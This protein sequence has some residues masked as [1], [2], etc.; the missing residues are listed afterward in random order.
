M[1]GG[2]GRESS[3]NGTGDR[4]ADRH[5]VADQRLARR[6]STDLPASCNFNGA[7]TLT[8]TTGDG[9][10]TGRQ[11]LTDT[12]TVAITVN[13]VNDRPVLDLD[14][15]NS[16]GAA[17][18]DYTTTFTEG[19]AAVAI[20]DVDDS[21]HRCRQSESRHPRRSR[22]PIISPPTCCPSSGRCRPASRPPPTIP[23]T[24]VLTLSGA[25]TL[26]AYQ[27]ALRQIAFSNSS[28][29]PSASDRIINIVVNDGAASSVAAHAFIHVVPVDTAPALDLDANDSS[30]ATGADY[31][32][33]FTG[34]GAAIPIADADTL[35]ADADSAN[36][37]SATITL[38]NAE[39]TDLLLVNGTLPHRDH[40]SSFDP[41]TGI[42]TLSGSASL[43]D[44][45]AALRQIEFG[46]SVPNPLTAT[47]VIEVVVNDG[48]ND[49]NAA[50]EP[51]PDR[52]SPPRRRSI[53]MPTIPPPA[54][55]TTRRHSPKMARRCG[56]R[57]PTL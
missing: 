15:D 37:V 43:A 23:A 48:T 35:V 46:S 16:S 2:R 31:T 6:R 22:S 40:R 30:G 14:A 24:G 36:L 55:R 7:D 50:F 52:R 8:L 13:A 54:A 56:S 38:T 25:A 39:A 51:D 21:D 20:A 18:V 4:D 9:G 49:S 12:D 34:G 5:G 17:G 44:Y 57:T 28:P 26:A 45:Q 42:L 27:A 32:A 11:A 19:G 10:N 33:V 47:R 3:G 53:S 29:T 41:V 1:L